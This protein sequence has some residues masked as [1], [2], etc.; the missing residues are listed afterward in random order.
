MT[1]SSNS[2]AVKTSASDTDD[3]VPLG[4]APTPSSF[5][6]TSPRTSTI[7]RQSSLLTVTKLEGPANFVRIANFA[8]EHF[9]L[10]I[11]PSLL[12][13]ALLSDGTN[14]LLTRMLPWVLSDPLLTS[15]LVAEVISHIMVSTEMVQAM[16]YYRS[17]ALTGLHNKLRGP[18]DAAA[19][20]VVLCFMLL[21]VSAQLDL[22]V[23]M[24][25]FR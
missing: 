16:S 9:T 18:V 25:T 21:E 4:E 22:C 3:A 8:L 14:G 19:I 6:P 11:A 13:M 23:C 15:A 1:E 5:P 7:C 20:Q 10:I 2:P 24:L 12:D 17:S